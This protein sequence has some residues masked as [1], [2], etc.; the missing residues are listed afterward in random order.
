[1]D[2]EFFKSLDPDWKSRGYL[3]GV[4]TS[5]RLILPNTD[6]DKRLQDIEESLAELRDIIYFYIHKRGT[7]DTW[8]LFGP[9]N[10]WK[11]N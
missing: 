7:E 5:K 8:S 3:D 2:L 6:V 10:F 11:D 9:S 1:M 4:I